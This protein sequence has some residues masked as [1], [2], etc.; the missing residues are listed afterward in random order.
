MMTPV[1]AKIA[2]SIGFFMSFRKAL[3]A[4][5]RPGPVNHS[6]RKS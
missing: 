2:F 1:G 3:T 5:M 4:T 6:Q